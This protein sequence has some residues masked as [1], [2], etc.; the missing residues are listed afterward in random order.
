MEKGLA[1]IFLKELL[2][3]ANIMSLL[4]IPITIVAV[5]FFDNLP[6]FI[7]LMS[8]AALTDVLDGPI[9]RR[10]RPT[11][12]GPSID[13]FADK[14]IVAI[15]A[16]FLFIL[17]HVLLWQMLLVMTRDI[18]VALIAFFVLFNRKKDRV[19]GR[20]ISRWPS[21]LTT[22]GQFV[23]LIWLMLR[24][25]GLNYVVISVGVMGLIASVDY[26]L[27]VKKILSARK[28]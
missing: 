5:F 28:G 8:L 14:T 22:I 15:V 4:R 24:V 18:L 21:K 23:A 2:A 7:T 20:N 19:I 9:A 17:G 12:F 11:R 25:P 6:L 16:I 1:R 27:F 10:S 26:I 13:G 3:P